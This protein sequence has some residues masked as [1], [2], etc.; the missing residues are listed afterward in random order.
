L[1]DID[2]ARDSAS[3]DL[4]IIERAFGSIIGLVIYHQ[5]KDE[6]SE[7]EMRVRVRRHVRMAKSVENKVEEVRKE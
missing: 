6:F 4:S 1:K 2:L 5:F 7:A 3:G